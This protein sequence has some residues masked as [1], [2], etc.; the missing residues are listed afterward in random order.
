MSFRIILLLSLL[1]LGVQG[2]VEFASSK[3]AAPET[4][5]APAPAASTD[6]PGFVDPNWAMDK[7]WEDGL[8][9]VAIYDGRFP[10]YGR[11]RQFEY[12]FVTVKETFNEEFQVKT[13]SYQRDDLYSVMKLNMFADIPTENYPYHFLT[14]VFHRR[15]NPFH[16]HK[17]THSSQE[18]CGNTFK[19]FLPEGNKLRYR[20][21][22]YWDGEG[23][24]ESQLDGYPLM[25]DQLPYTLRS[26][27]F[28]DGLRF[29]HPLMATEV[30]SHAD[31]PRV[32]MAQFEITRTTADQLGETVPAW[33]VEVDGVNDNV[34]WFAQAYPNPLLK[35][36]SSNGR[37]LKL[38]SLERYA[39]WQ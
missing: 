33:K 39:Y 35:M 14:S 21:H 5:T 23:D 30:D 12:V 10:I 31:Q 26:L 9:E 7:L 24:G 28:E 34:Y 6:L 1:A 19:E 38:K 22:S 18:W 29:S 8:A 17:F 3:T 25:E 27:R 2:C 36:E 13:N 16:L 37:S 15:E 4:T 20:W 11:A 32:Q